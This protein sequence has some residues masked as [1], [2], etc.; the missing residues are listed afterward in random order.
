VEERPVEDQGNGAPYAYHVDFS[1]GFVSYNYKDPHDIRLYVRAVR[2]V[3]AAGAGAELTRNPGQGAGVAGNGDVN[4]DLTLDLSDAIYLL[5]FLFQGGPAP[6]PCLNQP[7]TDCGNMMDD[8]NDGDTDCADS[9]CTGD[10]SCP[11]P[12]S[13]LLPDTGQTICF[14]NAGIFLDCVATDPCGGQDGFYATGCA[15]D[16]NR[17][18]DNLDDTVTDTC[19]GLMWQQDPANTDGIAGVDDDDK[20]SWCAALSYCENLTFATHTDWRLPNVREIQSIVDYSGLQTVG[21]FA[22]FGQVGQSPEWYW[23][24]TSRANNVNVWRVIFTGA[25]GV[26]SSSRATPNLVRAVRSVP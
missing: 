14:T 23:S 20:L 12:D 21:V 1:A 6:E 19:T 2:S 18:V 26:S 9:D 10:V 8:D 13:S 4:G 7:E 17:F 25:P 11:E 3:P 5:S 22:P 15:S 24:S 16:E